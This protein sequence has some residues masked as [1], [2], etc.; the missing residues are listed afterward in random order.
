MQPLLCLHEQSYRLYEEILQPVRNSRYSI[1]S[2]TYRSRPIGAAKMMTFCIDEGDD[3]GA[4]WVAE[5]ASHG[6]HATW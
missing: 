2:S 1:T 5:E 6:T 3:E 4:D